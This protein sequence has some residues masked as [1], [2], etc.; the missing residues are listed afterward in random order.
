M[1]DNEKAPQPK[2]EGATRGQYE[3]LNTSMFDGEAAKKAIQD[4]L[5]PRVVQMREN[6]DFWKERIAK[7]RSKAGPDADMQKEFYRHHP[8]FGDM[9]AVLSAI[10]IICEPDEIEDWTMDILSKITRGS[11]GQLRFDGKDKRGLGALADY[12][13]RVA[14]IAVDQGNLSV[15]GL[16]SQN[17]ELSHALALILWSEE[18]PYDLPLVVGIREAA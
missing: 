5:A 9:C 18:W 3:H 4:E 10:F 7:W 11:D 13:E 1:L 17:A 12:M 8:A 16:A 2:L 6:V 14:R 15:A